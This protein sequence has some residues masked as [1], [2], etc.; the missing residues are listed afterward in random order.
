M[1][2]AFFISGVSFAMGK[3]VYK[4][5]AKGDGSVSVDDAAAA[6][7]ESCLVITLVTYL[8]LE[9]GAPEPLLKSIA[10]VSLVFAERVL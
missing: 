9:V 4:L 10:K 7:L 8:C 3:A 5:S 1:L 6:V 2:C